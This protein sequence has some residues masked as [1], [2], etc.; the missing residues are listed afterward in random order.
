MASS[1]EVAALVLDLVESRPATLGSGR[2][3]CVDGPAGSGKTTLAAAIAALRPGSPVVHTDDLLTGWRGLPTLHLAVDA[4]LRPLAA[5]RPGTYLR[6]DWLAG[7]PDETV[8]VTPTGLL[9][10]EGCGS[11]SRVHADLA[12]VLVWVSAPADQCLARGVE[13]DGPEVAAHWQQWARDEDEL[14]RREDT[15][16]RADV[17]VDGTGATPAVVRAP[18]SS[19]G[20]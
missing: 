13:R 5:D 12:T 6:Y 3:I 16:E 2:L 14:F 9:V 4:L 10:L 7:A 11:G 19:A 18:G 15:R 17:L 8:S 20:P 1:S